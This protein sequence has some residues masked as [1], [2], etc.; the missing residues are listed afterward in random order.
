MLYKFLIF[1]GNLAVV[2][3]T[4]IL[5]KYFNCLKQ[6][7]SSILQ[8]LWMGQKKRLCILQSCRLTGT[9][10]FILTVNSKQDWNTNN[11]NGEKD[12]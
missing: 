2:E 8:M 1:G 11:N 3:I 7:Y 4:E 9:V 6:R 10:G 5:H 12:K